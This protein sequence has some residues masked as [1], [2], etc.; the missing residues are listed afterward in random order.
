MSKNLSGLIISRTLRNDERFKIL[1]DLKIPFVAHGRSINCSS[2][3]WLDVDNER[4]FYD[5][6]KHFVSL[7]HRKIAHICVQKFII[8]LYKELRME[9]SSF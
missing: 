6:T 9:K 5:M 1:T 2:S 4:A 8:F 3:S 7:G